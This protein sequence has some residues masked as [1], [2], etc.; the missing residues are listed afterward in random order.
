MFHLEKAH[1]IVNEMVANGAIIENNKVL[2]LRPMQLL[3][4]NTNETSSIFSSIRG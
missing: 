3:D 2:I 4:K 1:Y